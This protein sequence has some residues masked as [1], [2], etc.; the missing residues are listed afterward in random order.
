MTKLTKYVDEKDKQTVMD[1]ITKENTCGPNHYVDTV[2]DR[3]DIIETCMKCPPG[4]GT[5]Y[6]PNKPLTPINLRISKHASDEQTDQLIMCLGG[7]TVTK[8]TIQSFDPDFKETTAEGDAWKIK[9][10]GANLKKCSIVPHTGKVQFND[11]RC[12]VPS[13]KHGGKKQIPEED[14]FSECVRK[15]HQDV[16]DENELMKRL[17]FLRTSDC[18]H[19]LPKDMESCERGFMDMFVSLPHEILKNH[20]KGHLKDGYRKEYDL[21]VRNMMKL[22]SEAEIEKCQSVSDTTRSLIDDT[23]YTVDFTFPDMSGLWFAEDKDTF[24]GLYSF[25]Q[26]FLNFVAIIA[27]IYIIGNLL[28]NFT[29]RGGQSK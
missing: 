25:A 27:A 23:K 17:T 6:F 13:P 1:Y 26:R 12:P 28:V 10:Q 5:W 19:H 7:N 22:S 24:S 15:K 16:A 20:H 21:S 18:H 3:D 8:D 2:V 11:H 9:Q 4:K 29:S 14:R